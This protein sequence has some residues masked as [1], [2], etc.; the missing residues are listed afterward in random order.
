MKVTI[1]DKEITL[2]QS[3]RALIAYEQITNETFNPSTITDMILYFYCVIISSKEFD[4]PMTFEEFMDYLDEHQELLTDFTT[5]LTESSKQNQI[6]E[7][8]EEKKQQSRRQRNKLYGFDEPS[9]S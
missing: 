8:K 7:D 5:W 2:K 3:F 9:L 4:E 1:K 6:F